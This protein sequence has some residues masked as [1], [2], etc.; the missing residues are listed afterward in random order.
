MSL[1]VDIEETD[2]K[3]DAPGIATRW[4]TEPERTA[5]EAEGKT[6]AA[7]FRI[8]T[9]KEAVVKAHGGGLAAGL[10]RFSVATAEDGKAIWP[11]SVAWEG[12]TYTL[13]DLDAGPGRAAALATAGEPR[14]IRLF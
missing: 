4:F 3:I 14:R 2:R 11:T 6:P 13:H 12:V 7:F 1:G 10:G 9:R 8:W 5:W